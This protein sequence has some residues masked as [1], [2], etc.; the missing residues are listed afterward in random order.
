MPRAMQT[1]LKNNN[2][3]FLVQQVLQP[4]REELSLTTTSSTK[5]SEEKV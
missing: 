4:Y 3:M 2:H 1:G 5:L